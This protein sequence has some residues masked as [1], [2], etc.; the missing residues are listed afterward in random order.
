MADA[1]EDGVGESGAQYSTKLSNRRHCRQALS[2]GKR[3]GM[4]L[5]FLTGNYKDM[6]K[7]KRLGFAAIELNSTALGA[8][9]KKA[10]DKKKIAE[11]K[12]ISREEGIA[13]T[14]ITFYDVAWHTPAPDQFTPAFERLFDAA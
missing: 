1:E 14:A 12:T 2:C 13:I 4:K 8:A 11:A 5:G 6:A 10:L 3:A 9:G 7:A